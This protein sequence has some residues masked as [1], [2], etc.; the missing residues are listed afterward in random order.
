MPKNSPNVLLAFVLLTLLLLQQATACF[1]GHGELAEPVAVEALAGC[2][3]SD[4]DRPCDSEPLA[5]LDQECN[6]CC[7]CHAGTSLCL[8]SGSYAQWTRPGRHWLAT[9]DTTFSDEVI[10]ALYRPPIS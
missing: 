9:P 2:G 3:D 5:G 1:D 10:S 8:P 7:H 4:G 6:H